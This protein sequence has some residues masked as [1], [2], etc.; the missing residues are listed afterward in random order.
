MVSFK[1]KNSTKNFLSSR[2]ITYRDPN[3]PTSHDSCLQIS[4]EL[5]DVARDQAIEKRQ[6]IA[7]RDQVLRHR[8]QVEHRT[9]VAATE[10]SRQSWRETKDCVAVQEMKRL[11]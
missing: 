8:R 2:N 11:V 5:V 10:G 4:L 3:S 1:K 6:R 7:A 9:G